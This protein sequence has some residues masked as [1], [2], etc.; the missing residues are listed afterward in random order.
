MEVV[1]VNSLSVTL[2]WRRPE[3]PNGVITHYS[4]LYN[5]INTTDFGNNTLM[6]TIEGLSPDTVYVLQLSAH[7]G[8]G[9]GPPSSLTVLT[10][11]LSNDCN[12][13]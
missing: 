11:K 9:A 6:G 7:T 12:M 10:R 13:A 8:A 1:S 3:I 2:Q 5:G 4:I